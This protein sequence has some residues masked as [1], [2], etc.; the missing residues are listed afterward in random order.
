MDAVRTVV[1]LFLKA[2][3]FGANENE[4]CSMAGMR[5]LFAPPYS[6]R[7]ELSWQMYPREGKEE[8]ELNPLKEG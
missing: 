5:A 3:L 2:G 7:Y 1:A 4:K 8:H 6:Q